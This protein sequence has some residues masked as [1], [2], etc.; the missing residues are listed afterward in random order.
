[1]KLNR[2]VSRILTLPEVQQRLV[3]LGA[4]PMP[5]TPQQFDKMLAAQLAITANLARKAGIK[6][7]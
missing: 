7:E 2:E 5:G 4:E 6:A 3:S 1:M